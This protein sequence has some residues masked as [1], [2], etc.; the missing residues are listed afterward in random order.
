MAK[1]R[2]SKATTAAK[3]DKFTDED[4]TYLTALFESNT[5]G[6]KGIGT[7]GY[8]YISHTPLWPDIMAKTFG[9]TAEEFKSGKGKTLYGWRLSLERRLELIKAVEQA[10]K[11]RG[12][13][14]VD[15]DKIKFQLERA[16]GTQ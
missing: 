4:L 11:L 3:P 6:I 9:G 8:V 2:T 7:V 1:P 12:T 10:G 13:D 5:Q 15:F 16:I 14:L